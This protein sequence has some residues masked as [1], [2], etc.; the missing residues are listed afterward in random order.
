MEIGGG[1]ILV[2]LLIIFLN[3]KLHH[4]E[5]TSLLTVRFCFQKQCFGI[6]KN[7]NH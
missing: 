6:F 1:F 7:R 2:P 5:E 4:A 3:M